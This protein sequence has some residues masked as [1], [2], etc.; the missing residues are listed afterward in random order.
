MMGHIAFLISIRLNWRKETG[1]LLL[2]FRGGEGGCWGWGVGRGGYKQR[3]QGSHFPA[4]SRISAK[5][6]F[7]NPRKK[8]LIRKK[9]QAQ[10]IF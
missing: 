8:K 3:I 4:V 9:N 7:Q 6:K 1:Q 2:K 5:M 10:F